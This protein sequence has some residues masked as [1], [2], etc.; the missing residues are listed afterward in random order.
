LAGVYRTIAK[1]YDLLGWNEFHDVAFPHLK[2]L[3][4]QHRPRAYLDL[5]CGTGTL[6]YSVARLGVEVVGLDRSSEMLAMAQ[7]RLHEFAG[8]PKPEFV[9]HDMTRF[10]LKRKF[11]AVGCFFDA[12]NHILTEEGFRRMCANVAAHLRRGGFFT[13]DVNTS[14][15]MRKWD[16]VLFSKKG[17]YALVMKGT[18]NVSTRLADVTVSGF[19]QLAPGKRD[20]FRV[21]FQERAY[22]HADVVKFLRSSGFADIEAKPHKTGRTLRNA[23]RVFYTAYKK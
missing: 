9:R 19:V 21:T 3:L 11:D 14:V 23:H 20:D 5:A 16:A 2:A 10:N 1:Y 15:G 18:Y 8:T 17:E 7:R 22:P 4:R 6:A 12:A 13:F